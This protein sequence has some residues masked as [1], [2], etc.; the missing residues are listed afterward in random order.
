MYLVY[1]FVGIFGVA[2]AFLVLM[3][4]G[5]WLSARTPRSVRC[6]DDG[7]PAR[8]RLDGRRA[9]RSLFTGEP[10]KVESC[11]RW[12]EHDACSRRCARER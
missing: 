5:V 3:L 1:V 10:D 7:E 2:L 4:A 12:P 8:I 11:S 9:L 6:P